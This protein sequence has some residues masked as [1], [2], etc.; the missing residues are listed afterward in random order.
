MLNILK[1]IKLTIRFPC[2]IKSAAMP[3]S[4]TARHYNLLI[5]QKHT[6]VLLTFV[7]ILSLH[8]NSALF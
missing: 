1:Q 7:S 2:A 5:Q 8:L 3:L 6:Y 4:S